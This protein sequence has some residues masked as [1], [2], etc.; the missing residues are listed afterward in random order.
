MFYCGM[1]IALSVC[2]CAAVA[3]HPPKSL[4]S[5]RALATEPDTTAQ[6]QATGWI[7]EEEEEEQGNAVMGSKRCNEAR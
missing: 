6:R 2:L 7:V 5:P 3:A 4:C 1:R